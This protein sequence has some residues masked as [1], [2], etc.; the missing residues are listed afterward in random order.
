LI[1]LWWK[2]GNNWIIERLSG[3]KHVI[4]VGFLRRLLTSRMEMM[5]NTFRDVVQHM[6]VVQSIVGASVMEWVCEGWLLNERLWLG[7]QMGCTESGVRI[8]IRVESLQ[9]AGE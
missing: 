7:L 8:G 6:L 4:E 2:A 9:V 1:E 5:F 3:L